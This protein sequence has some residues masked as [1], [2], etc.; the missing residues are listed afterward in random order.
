MTDHDASELQ[1]EI[2]NLSTVVSDLGREVARVDRQLSS[3]VN[4][5]NYIWMDFWS[6]NF[7]SLPALFLLYE[8]AKHW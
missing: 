6:W 7:I 4:K 8:I 2:R 5:A 1:R 3:I